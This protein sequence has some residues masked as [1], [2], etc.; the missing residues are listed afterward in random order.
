MG[1]GC[2]QDIQSIGFRINSIMLIE[3]KISIFIFNRWDLDSNML[4]RGVVDNDV[5]RGG[6]LFFRLE[7]CTYFSS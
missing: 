7:G 1:Y 2:A 4:I 5:G 6:T 3:D